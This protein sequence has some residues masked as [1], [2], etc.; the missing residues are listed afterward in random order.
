[1]AT[2]LASRPRMDMEICTPNLLAWA[3]RHAETM[4]CSASEAS[5]PA[6]QSGAR[7]SPPVQVQVWPAEVYERVTPSGTAQRTTYFITRSWRGGFVW[8]QPSNWGD[9]NPP[10]D[11]PLSDNPFNHNPLSDNPLRD[12]P[13]RD[14]PLRDSNSWVWVASGSF[15]GTSSRGP[16][17]PMP[18]DTPSRRLARARGGGW[19]GWYLGGGGGGGWVVG[20]SRGGPACPQARGPA[21]E[22]GGA[23]EGGSD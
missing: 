7:P 12:R 11:R 19:G 9:D 17:A 8:N 3:A 10:T 18:R 1:M 15:S 14:R 16:H 5:L 21:G 2:P 13:L 20:P 6:L 22:G 4:R 23:G